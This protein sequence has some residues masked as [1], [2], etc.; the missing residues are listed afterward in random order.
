MFAHLDC[1]R[2]REKNL[3]AASVVIVEVDE[4]EPTLRRTVASVLGRSPAALLHE[5]L[6]VD[7]GSEWRVGPSVRTLS[8]KVRVLE[9]GRREGLVRSRLRGFAAS[10]APIVVFLDAHVECT[11]G[12]IEPL[13]SRV[14]SNPRVIA[15]PVIDVIHPSSFEYKVAAN[16]VRGGFDWQLNFRWVPQQVQNS[17]SPRG[18][19]GGGGAGS[20]QSAPPSSADPTAPIPTPTIAGGLFAVDR[21]WFESIGTYDDG[22]MIWGQENLELSFRQ[23]MC[24]GRLEVLPCSHVGH[25]FRKASPLTRRSSNKTMTDHG[26]FSCA[27][28]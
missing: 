16:N 3:P 23:W 9:N 7:D 21:E 4:A 27:T 5:I 13:I 17:S 24:G 20:K 28:S 6:I 2:R 26:N 15:A 12:W 11:I 10:T 25:V 18:N 8:P 1:K 19:A 22:F 14:A